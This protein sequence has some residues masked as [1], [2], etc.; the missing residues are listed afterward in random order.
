MTVPMTQ[1][2]H[3]IRLAFGMTGTRK[4]YTGPLWVEMPSAIDI[5]ADAGFVEI[6]ERR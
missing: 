4:A 3:A 2:W 1:L 6:G 5:L